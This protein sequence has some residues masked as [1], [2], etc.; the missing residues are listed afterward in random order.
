MIEGRFKIFPGG[1]GTV[2]EVPRIPHGRIKRALNAT[3]TRGRIGDV[4]GNV[5]RSGR[6]KTSGGRRATR[7]RSG[8]PVKS[9][10]H[11]LRRTHDEPNDPNG[12]SLVPRSGDVQ[13]KQED[14]VKEAFHH[15]LCLQRADE[16]RMNHEGG[17]KIRAVCPAVALSITIQARRDFKPYERFVFVLKVGP[18]RAPCAA[19]GIESERPVYTTTVSVLR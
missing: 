14:A 11:D 16:C 15:F 8:L 5:C 3:S 19:S 7:K 10:I 13:N 4:P 12:G 18:A 2:L 1:P 6:L 9:E 17:L